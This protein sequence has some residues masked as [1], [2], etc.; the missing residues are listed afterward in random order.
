MLFCFSW[1]D[2]LHGHQRLTQLLFW[3]PE[4]LCAVGCSPGAFRTN[5][6]VP[7]EKN[8]R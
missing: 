6:H 2:D 5:I 3:G 8:S 4:I 7:L 1:K